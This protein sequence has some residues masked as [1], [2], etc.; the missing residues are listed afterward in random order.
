MRKIKGSLCVRTAIGLLGIVLIIGM[1]GCVSNK[2][3]V[4]QK[5][6]KIAS[7][8][9]N[10]VSTNKENDDANDVKNIGEGDNKFSLTIED[11]DGEKTFYQVSTN[12]DNVGEALLELDLIAGEEGPY[13]LYIKSVN[14]KKLDYDKDKKYW[15]FYINDKYANTGV[16]QTKITEGDSYLFK[17]E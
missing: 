3:N 11:V 6:E 15:A 5:T 13:G 8:K 17:A 2:D 7:D 4:N 16:E 10:E 14:G 9:K 1:S 12:K